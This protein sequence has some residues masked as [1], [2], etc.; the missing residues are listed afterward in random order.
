M[1]SL[2]LYIGGFFGSISQLTFFSEISTVFVNIS[3]IYN[4]HN[5]SQTKKYNRNGALTILV[6]FVTKVFLYNYMILWKMQDMCM[7]R[8][9]SFWVLYPESLHK[10]C[11]LYIFLYFLTYCQQL[12]K[13]SV[14]LWSA[15][16]VLGIDKA[17][18]ATERIEATRL[19]KK[20][21]DWQIIFLTTI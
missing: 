20:K 3:K 6:F 9:E 16:E 4:I 21:Q 17:I 1:T 11:Y 18:E 7:Y 15:F 10:T 12:F 8:F 19:T 5:E 13:F 14:M 2:G